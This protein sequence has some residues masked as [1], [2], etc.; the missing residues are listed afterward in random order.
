MITWTKSGTATLVRFH[1][2]Y[3]AV[4]STISAAPGTPLAGKL[5]AQGLDLTV[6]VKSCKRDGDH[7]VIEGRLVNLTRELREALGAIIAPMPR[8][9]DS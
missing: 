2:P 1:E 3:A 7:F 9:S 8:E 6:K 4:R 5:D